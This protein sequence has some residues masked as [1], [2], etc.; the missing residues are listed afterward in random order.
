MGHFALNNRKNSAYIPQTSSSLHL[1]GKS[2][3]ILLLLTS[4]EGQGILKGSDFT[5]KI[6][7]NLILMHCGEPYHK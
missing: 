6:H 7:E 1:T 3:L 4:N 5:S 2:P